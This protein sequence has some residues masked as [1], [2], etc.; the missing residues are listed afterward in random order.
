METPRR[1][2]PV[3]MTA[4]PLYFQGSDDVL[5]RLVSVTLQIVIDAVGHLYGNGRVDE[6]GSAYLVQR[7]SSS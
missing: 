7:L 5:H 4:F 6:V 1:F 3:R 2:F